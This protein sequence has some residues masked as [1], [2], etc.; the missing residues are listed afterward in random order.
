MSVRAA[1]F[2]QHGVLCRLDSQAVKEFFRP[3]LPISVAELSVRIE[4]WGAAQAGRANLLSAAVWEEFWRE[5]CVELGLPA[6]HVERL[7]GFR[8]RDYCYAYPDALEGLALAK[9]QG[10]RVGVLSNMP[11]ATLEGSLESLGFAGLL[12]AVVVPQISSESKPAP[13]AYLM[14]AQRLGV[15]AEECLFFDDEEPNVAGAHAV[16]MRAYLVDRSRSAHALGER[17]VRDLSSL[18]DILTR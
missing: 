13:G 3:L 6:Q 2:D 7:L 4:R 5:L 18:E 12:D 11:F 17:V 10:M 1:V 8:Y 14:A 9:R 16:G 15:T